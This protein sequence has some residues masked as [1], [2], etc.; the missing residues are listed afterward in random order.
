MMQPFLQTTNTVLEAHE[1]LFPQRCTSV[2]HTHTHTCGSCL[3]AGVSA[4]FHT[5]RGISQHWLERDTSVRIPLVWTKQRD[6]PALFKQPWPG[7]CWLGTRHRVGRARV[8][9]AWNTHTHTSLLLCYE[10]CQTVIHNAT[11]ACS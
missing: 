11:L 8:C 9:Q 10:T 2:L 6:Y 1:L 5:F 7:L 4:W 3:L